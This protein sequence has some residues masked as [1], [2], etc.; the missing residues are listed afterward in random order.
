M[1]SFINHIKRIEK[2]MKMNIIEDVNYS[3]GLANMSF[4]VTVQELLIY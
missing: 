4:P 2:I 1:Y 3:Y